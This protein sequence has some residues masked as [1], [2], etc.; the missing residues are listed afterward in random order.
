[1]FKYEDTPHIPE[2]AKERTSS[3]GRPFQSASFMSLFRDMPPATK[4][5]ELG[6]VLGGDCSKALVVADAA[7]VGGGGGGDF[8]LSQRELEHARVLF[9]H[10]LTIVTTNM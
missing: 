9:T 10:F 1:M 8:G 3:A 5:T 6:G 7:V 2:S 4:L